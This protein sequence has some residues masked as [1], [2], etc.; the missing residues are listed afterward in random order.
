[1]KKRRLKVKNIFIAGVIVIL[2]VIVGIVSYQKF[3]ASTLKFKSNVKVEVNS[4]QT[5]NNYIKES[6]NITVDKTQVINTSKLGK[7]KITITYK[8]KQ[9]KKNTINFSYTVVD[10]KKPSIKID[11]TITLSINSKEEDLKDMITTSDNSKGDV[12]VK[13]DGKYDL[14]KE[15]EYKIKIVAEDKSGNKATKEVTLNIKKEEIST[16]NDKEEENENNEV[17]NNNKLPYYIKINRKQ[18]VVMVYGLENGEYTKLVKVFTCSTGDAT[19]L[20][21][22]NTTDKYEWRHLFGDV[23]GQYATRITG[24]ILFHSVPYTEESKDALEWEEYNKLGTPASMGCIRLRVVDVKWIYDNCP[25]GTT[26]TIYDSDSLEG[27]EK[28][29]I[30]KIDGNSENRGWDPTDPDP[31]NPW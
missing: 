8:T 23:Y 12:S 2:L 24:S 26:V 31:L 9:G 30:K 4:K 15:G 1:M 7:Q 6:K 18:N 21:T 29:V 10:T 16:S 11:D 13:I 17:S 28:P 25:K 5:I 3:L 14:T 19:P 22:F 20:G 27:I